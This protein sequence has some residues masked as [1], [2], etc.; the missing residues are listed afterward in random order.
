MSSAAPNLALPI[1]STWFYTRWL[2]TGLPALYS[3]SILALIN[4]H[5]FKARLDCPPS[6]LFMRTPTRTQ[7]GW[8]AHC[9]VQY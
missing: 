3:L 6:V 7:Y 4:P 5:N 2:A 8:A 1:L 9:L